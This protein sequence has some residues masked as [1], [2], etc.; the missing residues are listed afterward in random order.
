MRS[1]VLRL[2]Q[3][4]SEIKGANLLVAAEA[5]RQLVEDP[6]KGAESSRRWKVQ[7]SY[8]DSGL[9]YRDDEAAAYVAARMPAVFSAC[10]RVLSEVISASS[11]QLALVFGVF[12]WK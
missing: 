1:K 10:H 7:S 6:R 11:F 8:G 2:S 12:G 9:R 5:S 3:S 4:L